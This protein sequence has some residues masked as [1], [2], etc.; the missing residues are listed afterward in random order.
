VAQDRH[1]DIPIAVLALQ[2]MVRRA[3]VVPA[4][5]EPAA[6]EYEVALEARERIGRRHQSAGEEMPAE[7]VSIAIGLERIQQR[8]MAEDVCKQLAVGAQP[9]AYALE[10]RLVVAQVLEHLDRH[11]AVETSRR[12]VEM[13]DVARHHLHVAQAEFAAARLDELA[14][15][16]RIGN[17]G[18]ARVRIAGGHPQRQRT[19]A[20]A[21]LVDILAIGERGALAVQCEHRL[22]CLGQRFV[23]ARVVARGILESRPEAVAEECRRQLVMLPVRCIGM[24]RQRAFAQRSD[25]QCEAP[26]LRFGSARGFLA[27]ALRALPADTG[28]QDA[29]RQ[30]AAFCETEQARCGMV[31]VEFKRVHK[32]RHDM[33]SVDGFFGNHGNSIGVVRWYS[34]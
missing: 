31:G 6:L 29:V 13:I 30:P 3:L 5:D 21:E 14:L 27:Q 24:D 20:A 15:R 7:P 34:R 17:G 8:A 9:R 33:S 10:Q 11:A 19:P 2:P 23:S 28:T 25:A 22:L 16:P 18:D 26:R 32:R 1:Q 12:Q 4:V